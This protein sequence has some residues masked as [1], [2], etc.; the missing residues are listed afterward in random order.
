MGLAAARTIAFSL[1]GT[2]DGADP[3]APYTRISLLLGTSG[4]TLALC[5]VSGVRADAITLDALARVRLAARRHGCR[6]R[7]RGASNDLVELLT[8]TGFDEVVAD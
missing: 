5:D 7:L 3:A 1:A 8:Y 2:V 6:L 4:A